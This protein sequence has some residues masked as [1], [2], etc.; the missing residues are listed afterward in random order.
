M[1]GEQDVEKA[2]KK[3]ADGGFMT[4][5][6]FDSAWDIV[7]EV[8]FAAQKLSDE[9]MNNCFELDQYFEKVK[10]QHH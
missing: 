1:K 5:I 6:P 7:D 2:Y 3:M 10:V 8:I 9:E 4:D